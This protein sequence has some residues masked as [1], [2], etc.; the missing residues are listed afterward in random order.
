MFSNPKGVLNQFHIDPGMSVADF[1]VG[2]GHYSLEIADMVGEIGNV[3]SFDIQKELLTKLKNEAAIRDLENITTVWADLD[4]PRSTNLADQSMDRVIIANI[5]F[6]TEDKKALVKEAK[7]ILKLRGRV[8]IVDWVESFGGLGP[9]KGDIV[10]RE[11]AENLFNEEGF[12]IDK[13]IK[14]GEHHYS[15]AAKLQ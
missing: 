5:L 12:I 1:G 2:A 14:A 13:D 10:S 3:Y 7:R 11:Q 9:Q 8:L 4:E 15:F 6:Q